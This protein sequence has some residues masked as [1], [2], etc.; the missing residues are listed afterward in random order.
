[1][2]DKKE[3]E[4]T[5]PAPRTKRLSQEKVAAARAGQRRSQFAPD[6][7][8][9]NGEHGTRRPTQQR[10][11]SRQNRQY[12]RHSE[13]NANSH[14]VGHIESR[15]LQQRQTLGKNRWI[16]IGQSCSKQIDFGNARHHTCRPGPATVCCAQSRVFQAKGK[17]VAAATRVS[18]AETLNE[19]TG[20]NR[21]ILRKRKMI[22]PAVPTGH[23]SWSTI[24]FA[25]TSPV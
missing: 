4:K 18:V 25:F 24:D 16:R 17:A 9:A 8:V 22:E 11:R 1:L 19:S 20:M 7:A 14:H 5:S 6:H 12:Q 15:R 13:K 21:Q 3:R 10:L 23:L 2:P